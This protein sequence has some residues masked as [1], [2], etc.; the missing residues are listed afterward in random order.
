MS[1]VELAKSRESIL[2]GTL[3]FRPRTS[4][5]KHAFT[6]FVLS[7]YLTRSMFQISGSIANVSLDVADIF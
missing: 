1:A 7:W 5:L 2:A 3:N 6:R 4:G